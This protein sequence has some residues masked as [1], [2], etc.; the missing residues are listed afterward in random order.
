MSATLT[1][2]GRRIAEDAF[3]YVVAELGHNHGGSVDTAIQMIRRAADCGVEAVKLQKRDNATLYSPALLAMPYAHE[4]SYG[5]TYGEH[6]RALEFNAEAYQTCQRQALASGVACFATAF[7]E[8]SVEFLVRLG[9]PALKVASGG[10]TDVPLLRAVAGVGVPVILSTGGG[11]AQ[12]IDR[13]VTTLTATMPAS[14]LALLH[15][16]AAYPVRDYREVNLQC[17]PVLKARYPDCVIGWSGH[18]SGIALSLV[19]YALGARIL[20]HHVT[21]D[22]T[23]K[24]T[25]HA[26]SLEPSGLSKLLRDLRRAYEAMGDGVK[27]FYP[28]EVGPISKM[29]RWWVQ[30]RW[31]IGTPEE[32]ELKVRA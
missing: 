26:F 9:V 1:I 8:P 27:R 5:R 7:D 22:R 4:H 32:Q 31:Q 6:R 25:D 20:E 17:I 14:R 23:M 3:P 16:T 15:C 19:A 21:L 12:D 10:L 2:A 29:R 11:D 28:S 13:A 24:G 18:V 30:G